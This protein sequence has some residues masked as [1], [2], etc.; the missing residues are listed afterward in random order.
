[1]LPKIV[2]IHFTAAAGKIQPFPP[3]QKS[4]N[5][6]WA[7][8]TRSLKNVRSPP[9]TRIAVRPPAFPY[10]NAD[11]RRQSPFSKGRALMYTEQFG[12]AK[13]ACVSP[14]PQAAG[15]PFEGA[16]FPLI[17]ENA[18]SN[19]PVLLLGAVAA[20][21]ALLA[22]LAGAAILAGLDLNGVQRAILLIVAAEGTA[23]HAASNFMVRLF[24]RHGN[25]LPQSS[26]LLISAGLLSPIFASQ[27]KQICF[28]SKMLFFFT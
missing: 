19:A 14:R 13:A 3:P 4:K 15:F 8:Q 18:P 28:Q 22:G 7:F 9:A 21:H 20:A 12:R 1:M 17:A 16:P 26:F 5:A 25:F 27:F 2:C 10:G 11:M 24:L 23:G 6:P